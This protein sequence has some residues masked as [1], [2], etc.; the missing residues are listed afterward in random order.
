MYN[1]GISCNTEKYRI[2]IGFSPREE[3]SDYYKMTERCERNCYSLRNFCINRDNQLAEILD[4]VPN[5]NECTNFKTIFS[6]NVIFA[7][8]PEKNI[9]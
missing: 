5:W 9:I 6:T 4:K 1:E 2:L 8:L 3:L 7:K